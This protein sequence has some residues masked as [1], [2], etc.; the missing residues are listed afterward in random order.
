MMNQAAGRLGARFTVLLGLLGLVPVAAP[1][2]AQKIT[3]STWSMQDARG[4]FCIW[5]L[6][7]PAL[8]ARLAEKGTVFAPAGTGSSL[9]TALAQTIRD[10][11]RFTSWIP[12]AICVWFYR[13]I[14]IDAN[15]PI[16]AAADQPLAVVAHLMAAQAPRG[17]GG[18]G[19]LLVKLGSDNRVVRNQ[20]G[21]PGLP[22]DGLTVTAGKDRGTPEDR[23]EFRL[24]DTQITWI[25]HP[26]GEASVGTT[27]S[28][29]FGYAGSRSTSWKGSLETTPAVTNLMIGSLRI[30][31]KSLL[32][33]ALKSSPIRAVGPIENGGTGRISFQSVPARSSAG[34]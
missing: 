18:A 13:S 23:V 29:S 34:N 9:P 21:D 32:S 4:G 10:E 20:G 19:F 17:A 25:G 28:M 22:L 14:A 26:S 33:K 11:P 30:E 1:L 12:A 24:E 2:D 5:Y 27:R 15:K 6:V 8:A 7:D 31:G 16:V 3:E